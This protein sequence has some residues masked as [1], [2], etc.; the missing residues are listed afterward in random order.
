VTQVDTHGPREESDMN[1]ARP[2]RTIFRKQAL[3]HSADRLDGAVTLALPVSWQVIGYLLFAALV[4][5]LVFLCTASYSRVETVSGAVVLEQGFA[6]IVP[7]RSGVVEAL[8]AHDGQTVKP[9]DPLVRIRSEE[10]MAS[11]AT[12]P[13]RVLGALRE[14]DLRLADQAAMVLHAGAAS[15]SELRV[16]IGGL[17]GEIAS[18]DS[19]I[20]D[21][22]ELVA[23][24][25]AEYRD[26]KIVAA[27]GYV[28]RRDLDV[29]EGELILRRQQLAQLEQNR[30]AKQA[31]LSA[32]RRSM[33]QAG[34]T[35]DAQV[36]SVQSGRAELAQ[37][38]ALAEASQG[39]TITAPIAGMVTA[40]TARLGQT[41]TP[42]QPLMMV[43][44]IG[45]RPRVELYVPTSAAGF[46][47]TGQ[48]VR[49]AVDAFPYQRFG[50]IEA[51]IT[52]ISSIAIAR[53]GADGATTP[54]Y[55]VQARLAHPW[56]E[57]FGRRQPLLPGMVVTARIVTRR[58]TL[59]GW[60]FE[61]LFAVHRR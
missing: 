42:G 36:A 13:R 22:H 34:A 16:R 57:A 40:V 43:T 39:Y 7:S 20:A 48:E 9:G 29:R 37:H 41:A 61:P 38:V 23:V 17:T 47:A 6:A 53:A 59:F 56:V 51:R 5:A 58:Q 35:T 31:E 12:A 4:V 3:E 14:Q 50:A 30:V 24:A 49:V 26:A 25:E 55:L 33:E 8:P 15:R 60:L 28:S 52:G 45:G 46:L 19:Q 27:K 18:L 54:A 2:N 1:A 11:G 44:P 10:D 21:Q 32:A